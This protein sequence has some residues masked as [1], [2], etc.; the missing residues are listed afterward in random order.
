[1][2]PENFEDRIIIVSIHTDQK[3]R[4]RDARGRADFERV[5][6]HSRRAGTSGGSNPGDSSCATGT[7]RP[8]RTA[9]TRSGS[10][11]RRGRSGRRVPA[12]G[13]EFRGRGSSQSGGEGESTGEGFEDCD[14]ETHGRLRALAAAGDERKSHGGAPGTKG[15]VSASGGT[16]PDRR[17]TGP[18][19]LPRDTSEATR[20]QAP[21][22]P[23]RVRAPF[24]Q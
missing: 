17:V 19:N 3:S 8:I 11:S 6:R 2:Q 23:V 1:M 10:G 5:A 12:V 22:H 9:R 18:A 24:P 4:R 14:A 21:A 13:L 16:S 20:K 7:Q 15:I